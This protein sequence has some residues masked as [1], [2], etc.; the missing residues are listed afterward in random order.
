MEIESS[1]MAYTSSYL[2]PFLRRGEDRRPR[3]A[4]PN[5]LARPIPEYH[6]CYSPVFCSDFQT[7]ERTEDRQTNLSGASESETSWAYYADPDSDSG[8]LPSLENCRSK[9]LFRPKIQQPSCAHRRRVSLIRPLT[10]IH[11]QLTKYNKQIGHCTPVNRPKN[12]LCMKSHHQRG[13]GEAGKEGK[14]RCLA[15]CGVQIQVRVQ[16]AKRG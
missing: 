10:H 5:H 1:I 16:E 15:F 4:E 11:T 6:G 12:G 7:A 2:Q 8:R 3:A 13:R 14:K 9:Y